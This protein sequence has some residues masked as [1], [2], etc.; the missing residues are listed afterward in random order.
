MFSRG[1]GVSAIR[2]RDLGTEQEKEQGEQSVTQG[3]DKQ[4]IVLLRDGNMGETSHFSWLGLFKVSL[5]NGDG[6]KEA[7][8]GIVLIKPKYVLAN[9]D[10]IARIPE[11]IFL[12]ESRAMFLSKNG[13]P[14][15]YRPLSFVTHPEYD[16]VVYSSIAVVKLAVPNIN[17]LT[18]ICFSNTM[19]DTG[20]LHL[21]GYTDDNDKLE[22]IVFKIQAVE[23]QQCDQFYKDEG[24]V[25]PRREPRSYICGVHQ[26]S[27]E[28]CVWENGLVLA[29]NT[30]DQFTFIG[31]SL[32]GPGCGV[33]ARFVFMLHYFSWIESVTR[34]ESARRA[35]D[36][37]VEVHMHGITS[38]V[39]LCNALRVIN[40]PS[41]PSS[42]FVFKHDYLTWPDL[43][44]PTELKYF[45]IEPSYEDKHAIAIYPY[46]RC[47]QV[48][49]CVCLVAAAATPTPRGVWRG[50]LAV[51]SPVP[52]IKVVK[53][54]FGSSLG[55]T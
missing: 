33:P 5:D 9:A 7:V 55:K 42:V 27:R 2:Y 20:G 25:D 1:C 31:F 22:K 48:S 17:P 24:L 12:E 3:C 45:T 30:T 36:D 37:D 43:Y 13:V 23:K 4:R 28:P 11:N 10:D 53:S 44:D 54:S 49:S 26:F 50:V 15:Y 8:T 51:A 41:H 34:E 38:Y 47:V 18:P 14:V 40:P 46:P 19:Y 6:V 32:Y 29:A 16:S 35:D 39:P 21:F 52:L